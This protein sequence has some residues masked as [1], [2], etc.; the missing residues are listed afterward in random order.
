VETPFTPELYLASLLDQGATAA[1]LTGY[2]EGG[3]FVGRFLVDDEVTVRARFRVSGR[4]EMTATMP[5]TYVMVTAA[6]KGAEILDLSSARDDLLVWHSVAALALPPPHAALLLAGAVKDYRGLSAM[7]LS[8]YQVPAF[9]KRT[10]GTL[11]PRLVDATLRTRFDGGM[12]DVRI[13]RKKL[14]NNEDLAAILA[15]AVS[16]Y[17][18]REA[19][20]D[21]RYPVHEYSI[22]Q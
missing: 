8:R 17:L 7:Y 21:G 22:V 5:L 15:S 16:N 1:A 13:A 4:Q 18:D 12:K 11:G 3:Q 19:Q 2:E 20:H 9:D 6:T 14:G 10:A